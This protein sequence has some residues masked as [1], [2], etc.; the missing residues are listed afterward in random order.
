MC[1]KETVGNERKKEKKRGKKESSINRE[2]PTYRD[3]YFFKLLV[4]DTFV[5]ILTAEYIN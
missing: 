3:F 4:R 1:P 2:I 5:V